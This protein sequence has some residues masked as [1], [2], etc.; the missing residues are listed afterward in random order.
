MRQEKDETESGSVSMVHLVL[1][2]RGFFFF[3]P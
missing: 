3:C 2:V 1:A